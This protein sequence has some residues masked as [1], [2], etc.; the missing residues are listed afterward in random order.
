GE[1]DLPIAE[2]FYE[3]GFIREKTERAVVGIEGKIPTGATLGLDFSFEKNKS[4]S[5][6][7][8]MSPRYTSKLNLSM[9]HPLLKDFGVGITKT[10]IRLAEKGSEIARYEVK[11][12]VMRT[13]GAV[14]QGYWDFAFALENLE[15]KRQSLDLAKK[16]LYETD[17][18]VRAGELPP[19]NLIQARAG[20]ATREEEVITAENDALKVE[21][22]LKVLLDLPDNE[23]RLVPLDRPEKSS[24][25][26]EVNSSLDEAWENRP[27][28]KANRVEV[29]QQK[30]RVQYARN[31][32]L[33]RLDLIAEYGYNGLSGQPS[34]AV[35]ATDP[36]TGEPIF[37]GEA[38]EGTVFEGKTNANDAFRKWFTGNAF[39]TWLV[40]L[41]FEAPLSNKQAKSRYTQASLN[42]K[43]VKTELRRLEDQVDSQV[44]KSILDIRSAVKRMD[45]SSVAVELAHEQ[46][47]AEEIR[48]SA[49]AA[50][51]YDVLTFERELTD[52]KIR[53]LV[54]TIDYNKA[55]S[56]LRV[57]EGLSLEKYE[58]EFD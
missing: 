13:V 58:I 34:D 42:E 45:A 11:K 26:P 4:T 29:D 20:I 9:V 56:A 41:K 30:I 37:A 15:L 14:E 44:R 2:T 54:A 38:V 5:N 31:Q 46:L 7:Q 22:D 36:I 35:R 3:D 21:Y 16:L 23:M 19:I 33:P 50:T 6:I 55:W 52:M 8:T 49:G 25:I 53:E 48:F 1:Q 24:N 10:K 43:R 40:G 57:A 18:M 27:D 51:S 39:D 12:Q 47:E 32:L 28:L 17:I